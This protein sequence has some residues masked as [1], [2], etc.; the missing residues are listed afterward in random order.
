M[1]QSC[2]VIWKSSCR[3][4]CCK[5]VAAIFLKCGRC[6]V[7]ACP[8]RALFSFR[9]GGTSLRWFVWFILFSFRLELVLFL[10]PLS[11]NLR[12]C[13]RSD[14]LLLATWKSSRVKISWSLF[15]E[16]C[17]KEIQ[18]LPFRDGCLSYTGESIGWLVFFMCPKKTD[19]K[20]VLS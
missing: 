17:L 6:S 7:L 13:D 4:H 5:R 3:A 9:F 1:T 19:C 20:L 14:T 12:S 2:S 16:S 18:E 10:R 15:S 8:H 11:Q